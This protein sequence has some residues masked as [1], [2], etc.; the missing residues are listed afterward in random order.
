MCPA[1]PIE[2]EVQLFTHADTQLWLSIMHPRRRRTHRGLDFGAE[3][4]PPV[5]RTISVGTNRGFPPAFSCKT[6]E[7]NEPN[8]FPE[9]PWF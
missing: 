8:T 6:T 1:M 3:E 4:V 2:A 5:E 9:M 7:Q